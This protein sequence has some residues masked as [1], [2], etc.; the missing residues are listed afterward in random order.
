V[1]AQTNSDTMLASEPQTIPVPMKPKSTSTSRGR[2][3]RLSIRTGAAALN[4]LIE[5]PDPLLGGF[6]RN[7]GAASLRARR[8]NRTRPRS[9]SRPAST[10]RETRKTMCRIVFE[11]IA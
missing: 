9:G 8:Y 5:A 3:M 10:L 7:I 11:A 4:W 6:A 1:N 2:V